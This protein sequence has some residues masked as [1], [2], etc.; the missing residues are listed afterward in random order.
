MSKR[1]GRTRRQEAAVEERLRK[2]KEAGQEAVMEGDDSNGQGG[3]DTVLRDKG[4]N[5]RYP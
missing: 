4:R 5:K 1:R 2:K 3:A